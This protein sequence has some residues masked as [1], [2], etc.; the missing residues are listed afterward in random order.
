MKFQ[1]RFFAAFVALVTGLLAGNMVAFA[2]ETAATAETPA[3]ADGGDARVARAQ[4]LFNQGKEYL[5]QELWTDALDAF[6]QSYGLVRRPG[7]L[8]NIGVCLRA[9][10]RHREAR[11]AFVRLLTDHQNA[12]AALLDQARE[13]RDAEA[14]VVVTLNLTNLPAVEGITLRVD[15]HDTDLP[16]TVPARV[17]VD[18]G[19]RSLDVHAPGYHDWHWEQRSTPGEV[20][21]VRVD[22]EALPETRSIVAS[23]WFWIVTTVVLAAAGGVTYYLL[24]QK[25]Q[26]MPMSPI[27]VHL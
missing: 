18:P 19:R 22:M 27:T 1:H 16:R 20:L 11:D 9:L 4:A 26:L 2:Q 8:N 24:D 13:F 25:A 10:G 6:Q 5:E 15:G 14:R 23:P 21:D 3:A 7:A 17:E 12:D